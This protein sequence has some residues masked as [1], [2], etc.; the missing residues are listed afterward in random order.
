[1][2]TW[3][4]LDKHRHQPGASCAS[5]HS[6]TSSLCTRR[7]RR[8]AAHLG[9]TTCAGAEVVVM[10][11]AQIGGTRPEHRVSER[12]QHRPRP[13]ICSMRGHARCISVPLSTCMISSS[14]GRI[15]GNDDWY[16]DTKKAQEQMIA[17]RQRLPAGGAADPTLMF[18]LVSTAKHL[19]WLSRFMQQG[20]A[21]PHPRPR[22]LPAP[23]RSMPERLLQHPHQFASK[24]E[25]TGSFQ[26]LR[27][28]DKIDYIDIIRQIKGAIRS[29]TL[30]SPHPLLAV[31]MHCWPS[32]ALF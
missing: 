18:R 4:V 1:M 22:P 24:S 26:H 21:L 11:Q 5:M 3:V 19:G 27:L 9:A 30:I 13:R 2:P 7:P 8:A 17:N 28:G 14:V 29:R 10:L 31:S 23:S 12:K 16:T 15:R 6:R 20:A 25:I 32:G